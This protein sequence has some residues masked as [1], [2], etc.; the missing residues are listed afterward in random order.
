MSKKKLNCL[1]LSAGFG[2]RLRPLTFKK[3]KC[4]IEIKGRPILDYWLTN[5]EKL[6]VSST[7]VNTHY[8]SEQVNNF[9]FNKKLNS[10]EVHISHE[11]NLL[12]T[13]EL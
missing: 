13:A 12:G 4:L 8:L 3:P 9:I 11:P 10:M 5:L 6:G 7:I 2:T 1:L